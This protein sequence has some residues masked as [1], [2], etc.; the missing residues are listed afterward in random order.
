VDILKLRELT[1]VTPRCF[2]SFT[3]GNKTITL[4]NHPIFS[5]FWHTYTEVNL[6]QSCICPPILTDVLTLPC[7][8]KQVNFFHIS[9]NV[10]FKCH[11][12][13][14]FASRID[15]CIKTILPLIN[16]LINEALLVVDHVSIRY[17]FSSLTS[18]TGF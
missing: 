15:I 17:C 13:Y 14:V 6:Q 11:D 4:S 1:I 2:I 9:S 12:S 16:R 8:M 5:Y 7:E 18:L 3:H 10:R